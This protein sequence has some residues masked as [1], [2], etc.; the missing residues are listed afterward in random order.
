MVQRIITDVTTRIY[1]RAGSF[2]V[3]VT[4]RYCETAVNGG[5][6]QERV[7]RYED[8]MPDELTDLLD[9]IT[10]GQMPGESLDA[11]QA[12]LFVLA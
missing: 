1:R 6:I 2:S 3:Q 12:S 8:L 4:T 7:E 5:R 10:E 11:E 9:S